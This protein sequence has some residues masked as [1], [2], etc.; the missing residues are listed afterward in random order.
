LIISTFSFQYHS[1]FVLYPIS[2]FFPFHNATDWPFLHRWFPLWGYS[3]VFCIWI[4]EHA[5]FCI[6]PLPYLSI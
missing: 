1:S 6:N 3:P 4:L 2:S 5:L